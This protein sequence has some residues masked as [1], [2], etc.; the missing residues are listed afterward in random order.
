MVL[1]V[2][3]QKCFTATQELDVIFMEEQKPK[4]S[5][6]ND[7]KTEAEIKQESNSAGQEQNM[8]SVIIRRQVITT[9][10]TIEE[11]IEEPKIEQVAA[12]EIVKTS[13]STPITGSPQEASSVTPQDVQQFEEQSRQVEEQHYEVEQQQHFT[14]QTEQYPVTTQGYQQVQEQ[15]LE[16]TTT[17]EV[18]TIQGNVPHIQIEGTQYAEQQEE[19]KVGVEYTN[20][21]SVPAAQFQPTHFTGDG[22]QYISHQQ[23]QSSQFQ[24]YGIAREPE[25][26][27]PNSVLFKNDPN[28]ASSRMYQGS[29]EIQNSQSANNQVT[30]IGNGG[31]SYQFTASSTW[32]PTTVTTE[33]TTY[34]STSS[35]GIHQGENV[36]YQNYGGGTAAWGQL[37]EGYDAPIQEIDI[38]ECVNCGASIT[39]LWR[40]D[41][42]GH[43][44]C[45][46][47]GLY[48]R[49]NGV[50]RPPVRT[51]KKPPT[52]GNRRSGVSCA[53]CRTTTTTL[54]R[55]NNQG[56]PVCNACGL[57]FK[58]HGVNRPL[59][60]KKEGIQT[61]KRK[62][63]NAN[64]SQNHLSPMSA[65]TSGI[66]LPTRT[67]MIHNTMY[68]GSLPG[69]LAP[70]ADQYQF[71]LTITQTNHTIR[72]PSADHLNRQ[73]IS[74]L[75]P[76]EP[77]MIPRTVDEQATVITSTSV[78]NDL[79]RAEFG[80]PERHQNPKQ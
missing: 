27:P 66:G 61:R 52:N 79:H 22:N 56:E 43:Y 64:S 42:T 28:L 17:V 71:P 11:N 2:N 50:N 55:R 12:E 59:S 77:V 75:P 32:T 37:E 20:L 69:E 31:N 70:A 15:P 48:N 73:T 58:L 34:P 16:Y 10:G 60:M 26:S 3:K 36:S 76:L 25:D 47:C 7:M 13:T 53:N 49:I 14:E 18:A 72:L 5:A 65:G 4:V 35:I 24:N 19:A 80:H 74:N 9:A 23:F 41:G 38:K 6:F 68:Q 40:R 67:M 51:S 44:L 8:S 29:Y 33:Y 30:L 21:D 46:A 57:Y 1:S 63:K 78:A 54:W 45:N 62:P 39:P